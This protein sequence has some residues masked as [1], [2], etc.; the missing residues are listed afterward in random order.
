MSSVLRRAC[1]LTAVLLPVVILGAAYFG[2]STLSPQE[3]LR[4]GAEERLRYYAET[5]EALRHP[6]IESDYAFI[7][8]VPL[9]PLA[10][11]ADHL[12]RELAAADSDVERVVLGPNPNGSASARG[13]DGLESNEPV[14][15]STLP[16]VA[17]EKIDV[18]SCSFLRS[19]VLDGKA[20]VPLAM[21]PEWLAHG[22]LHGNPGLKFA[23]RSAA[24]GGGCPSGRRC[25]VPSG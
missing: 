20:V 23:G 4:L 1:M 18:A 8:G 5:R 17:E 12:L 25:R 11:G 24:T 6:E 16:L 13:T 22:A 2:I 15:S 21:L 7:E 3:Q 10:Q 14:V 9:I 19:H